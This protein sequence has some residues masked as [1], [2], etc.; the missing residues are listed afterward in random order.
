MQHLNI[1]RGDKEHIA[2][3]L[4]NLSL[5]SN[6][7]NKGKWP[8]WLTKKSYFREGSQFYKIYQEALTGTPAQDLKFASVP[9]R[10]KG[11][12]RSRAGYKNVAFAPNTKGGVFGFKK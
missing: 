3:L 7:K 6:E 11:K 5:F 12:K 4:A 1:K 10:Q 8:R 9:G 2:G